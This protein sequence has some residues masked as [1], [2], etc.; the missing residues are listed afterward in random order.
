[1]LTQHDADVPIVLQ[2]RKPK[3]AAVNPTLKG[4]QA[5]ERGRVLPNLANCMLVLRQDP[6][7]CNAFAFDQ[8]ARTTMLV[9]GLPELGSTVHGN[10]FERIRP[11][12]DTDVTQLQEYLQLA[13]I[14]KMGRETV[15]SAVDYRAEECGFHPVRDYLDG[16]RWDGKPRL[17]SWL[18]VYLQAEANPYAAGVG[19]MFMIALVARIY[20]P[21]AKAD[22][23]LVLE[24]E[25]GAR[26]STACRILGGEWF[27]DN[28]P[29]V[30]MG[31]D[32]AQHLRGKWLIEVAEMSALSKADHA[33]LKAF[34]TRPVERYRPSYGR[35]EV[36]EPRQCVFIGTTNKTAYLR[37]ETGGRRYW[38]VKVRSVDTDALTRD[39]DQLFAE[40]VEHYR[41]RAQWW[42]DDLF[43]RKHVKPE[44][45]ARFEA[46]AWEEAISA[47]VKGR[48][49]L[50]VLEIAREALYIE[51]ARLATSDQRRI[52]AILERIGLRRLPKDG[53]GNRPWGP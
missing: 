22:Y 7:I 26:K 39:R 53:K 11:V 28:L 15:H 19:R 27:S 8:M 42:P 29:D 35:K 2:T 17:D 1:M 36:T 3:I 44:Q 13:G 34:I 32:V 40:A 48:N 6:R 21:G 9:A 41:M 10:S 14:P 31:K 23:M 25:Q 33:A 37:D 5:D 12:T 16:L 45:E 30:H 50:T 51:T 52:T 20:Q 49:K 43:E 18:S 24:G 47:W 4:A 46:D 38:P